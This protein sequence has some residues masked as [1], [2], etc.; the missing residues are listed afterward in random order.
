MGIV[1]Q[2]C[3]HAVMQSCNH[4]MVQPACPTTD[5]VPADRSC[6]SFN[7]QPITLTTITTNNDYN[8]FSLSHLIRQGRQYPLAYIDG[9]DI[10]P[11]RFAVKLE[12]NR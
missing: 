4:E 7:R 11:E 1:L 9:T 12:Y 3:S 8:L 6:K 10:F 5:L 2:S